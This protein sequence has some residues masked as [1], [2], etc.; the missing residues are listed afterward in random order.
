MPVN[1]NEKQICWNS[2]SEFLEVNSLVNLV[3]AGDLN[4]SLSPKEKKGGQCGRD[5][6]LAFVEEIISNWDLNDLKPK[7]GRFT[8]SNHRAGAANIS[9]RLD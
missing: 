3:L 4:I 9:V 1:Y 8:W 7:S 5:F 2:I 6:M